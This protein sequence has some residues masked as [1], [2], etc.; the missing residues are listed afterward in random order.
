MKLGTIL[1]EGDETVIAR[2][3]DE[4]AVAL[5]FDDMDKLIRAGSEGL[6]R[7]NDAIEACRS[8][9]L[10]EIDL[11]CVDWLPPNPRPSKILGCAINN[12]GLNKNAF[13]PLVSPM[14][15]I[16][17]RNALTPHL[18]TIDILERHGRTF[19]EPE[20]V[21]VFGKTAKDIDE[22]N[23]L[24]YVFGYTLTNDVTANGIKFAE[25][26]IAV[27]ET[28]E[29]FNRSPKSWREI[30]GDEDTWL[31]FIYHSRSK[32]AD[33]FASMGPWITTKDEVHDP[34]RLTIRGSID[35]ELFCEDTTA[36][37][38]FRV[39]RVISEAATWFTL[40]PGD[41]LHPGTATQGT[42]ENPGGHLAIDLR[43]YHGKPCDVE[44][45]ELGK[46]T[47]FINY[48]GG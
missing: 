11:A 21:V 4:S 12:N 43:E 10:P 26:A 7:A 45:P 9:N 36:N 46:L 35:G 39:E 2:V 28:K 40:E 47:T 42:P 3:T 37:Y 24:D 19:P 48:L 16:K 1:F 44:I 23:A 8:G 17:G 32:A 31:Y 6:N 14:F 13:R 33:T 20:P 29:M 15:F 30:L 41:C 18:K 22:N 5:Q 27:K 25:D 34:N 38:F